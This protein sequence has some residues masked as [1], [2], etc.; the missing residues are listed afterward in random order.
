MTGPLLEPLI[1]PFY[2]IYTHSSYTHPL[3]P[4]HQSVGWNLR[5]IRNSDFDQCHKSLLFEISMGH[6]NF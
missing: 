3:Q 2:L 4:R 1:V 6:S 5:T